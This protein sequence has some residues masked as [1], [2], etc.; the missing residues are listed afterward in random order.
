MPDYATIE[1]ML[2]IEPMLGS[3]TTLTS[4]ALGAF[5]ADAE[6][7]V[8]AALAQRYTVPVSGS[9]PILA[10]IATDIA[11]YRVLSRRIFTQDRLKDSVWPGVF[12]EAR[13]LLAKLANGELL[14]YNSS[15]STIEAE[16]ANDMPWSSTEDYHSTFH[17]GPLSTQI[18]DRE[19][20]DDL[21]DERGLSTF[22]TRLR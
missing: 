4:G 13:D 11:L 9:P 12:K 6:A 1:R 8:N 7:E 3:V 17:E 5:L 20:L 16:S 2:T 15:G 22:T 10:S 14:L 19:K 21:A 18:I